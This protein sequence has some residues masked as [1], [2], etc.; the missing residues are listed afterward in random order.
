MVQN[1]LQ[2]AVRYNVPD[3][4][5]QATT[6]VAGDTAVLT[7]TN[8][9]PVVPAYETAGLFDAFHRLEHRVGSSRGIGLGLSIVRS[10]ARAHAGEARISA[11]QD[12][13]LEL[14][15]ELPL[16]DKSDTSGISA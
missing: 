5:V 6:H 8:T 3:G 11:R 13:G 2:N 16:G 10:V 14:T 15:V 4:W 1:L 9:G 7:V 12:G